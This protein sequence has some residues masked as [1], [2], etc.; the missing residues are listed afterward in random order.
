MKTKLLLLA[1]LWPGGWLLAQQSSAIRL[2]QVGFFTNGPKVVAVIGTSAT[3]FTVKSTDRNTTYYT[4]NLSTASTWALSG[5]SVQT[6]DFSSFVTPGN[7]VIDISGLGYSYPFRIGNDVLVDVNRRL[8]KAYYYNRCS[9]ALPANYAGKWSRNLGHPDTEVI[10]LPSAASSARPAGTKVASTKGWYDA[11]DFNL[12]ITNS[13]IGTY[14]PLTAYEQYKS[15]YDT[16]KLNIPES[17]NT[18]PDILDQVKWNTDWM[19]TMQDPNDGGVYFKKTDAVFD[20]FEMP[21]ADNVTRYMCK[22]TTSSAF[23]FAASMAVAYR[24]FKGWDNA[25]ATQC[26]NAAKAAYIWGA[27]NPNIVFAN[28]PAEGGYP[29][30]TTG[31][32]VDTDLSDEYEWAANELYI[33]TL[34]EAYYAKGYKSGNSYPLPNWNVTRMLG[35]VSLV[36]HRKNLTSLG[37]ADTLSMK[38][39]LITMATTLS[40]YQKNTSPYKIVMGQ[41]GKA[42]FD[43]G[44]NGFAARQSFILLNA[45]Q[46]TQNIDFLTAALSNVDYLLGRNAVGYCFVTSVGSKPSMNISHRQSAADGIVDP[47]PGWMPGG[48]SSV[49]YIS[50]GCA[51]YT[52]TPATS[53]FDQQGCYTKNEVDINWNGAACYATAATEYYRLFNDDQGISTSLA[54]D[55]LST[56]V[57]GLTIYPNPSHGLVQ[58]ELNSKTTEKSQIKVLDP[59]G[60]VV[61]EKPVDLTMGENHFFLDTSLFKK[62]MYIVKVESE[63]SKWQA[64]HVVE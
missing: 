36:Y 26:L 62:G 35:L 31:D 19:L 25:Y 46:L 63:T 57:M 30:I 9:A 23:D 17:S 38:N 44:S 53:Y 11:G 1:C 60:L 50:D 13:S 18:L 12:Y 14:S 16:L 59:L 24:V 20:G 52:N 42:Q 39:K 49:T 4:G 8:S 27:A 61:Y 34:D 41:G 5:E 40:N 7:Y 33:A 56:R 2:N 47:V 29:A 3:Q 28:P 51:N 10:I 48:P 37:F 21:E 22:K 55:M 6:A 54:D 64:K 45:Y 43:W 15:Y 32:Y 58:V